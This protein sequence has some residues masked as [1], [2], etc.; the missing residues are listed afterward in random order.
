MA[1]PNNKLT[2][3]ADTPTCADSIAVLKN[4]LGTTISTTSIVSGDT[5]DITAPDSTITINSASFSAY[6]SGATSNILVKDGTGT[7]VGSKVGSEWIVPSGGGSYNVGTTDRYGNTLPTIIVSS[8]TTLN[9]NSY[10]Y[11]DLYLSKL[12]SPPTGA[13]LTAVYTFFDDLITAGIFQKSTAIYPIIGGTADDHKWNA[14][15]PFN[16]E[17]SNPLLFIGSPTQ[18]STGILTNGTNQIVRTNISCASLPINNRQMSIYKRN[19]SSPLNSTWF[20][21]GTINNGLGFGIQG[22]Y[23]DNKAY[24]CF[25]LASPITLNPNTGNTQG[26]QTIKRLSNTSSKYQ[27][28]GTTLASS[29]G[30]SSMNTSGLFVIGGEMLSQGNITALNP[31]DFSYCYIGEAL[32]DSEETDHY[33][34]VQ[35]LQTAF[36]RQ[37]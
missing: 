14:R 24:I 28:N 31:I 22:L 19:V 30:N 36:S 4:T 37:V 35:A 32:S 13:Q 10:D 3:I 17:N 25:E 9:W 5:S 8:N 27:R 26:L 20:G 33:N 1:L 23:G 15:Y 2:I 6:A 7:Q 11:A 34:I 21:A 16:T 12:V 29:A 18:S